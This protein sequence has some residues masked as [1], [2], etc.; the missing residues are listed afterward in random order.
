MH[1]QP[2]Y[3]DYAESDFF[4]DGQSARPI[5]QGTVPRGHL[6]TAD[7]IRAA[8]RFSDSIP[9]PIT[10]E[11]IARGRERY[12]IFC[13]PCHGRTG[14]GDGMVALRGFLAPPSFHTDRSRSLPAEYVF[15]VISNGFGGMPDYAEQVAVQDRWAIVAYL[16]ALQLTRTAS[17]GGPAQ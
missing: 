7:G 1:D 12:D 3:K 6:D 2:R 9:L 5:V 8:T 15:A 14:D 11:L 10:G 13:S 17:N 4:A 16:R